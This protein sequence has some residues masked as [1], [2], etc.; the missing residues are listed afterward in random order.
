MHDER[1]K[2]VNKVRSSCLLKPVICLLWV[3]PF[4]AALPMRAQTYQANVG[5][6][7]GSI[8]FQ[9]SVVYS[10]QPSIPSYY[11]GGYP[12]PPQFYSVSDPVVFEPVIAYPQLFLRDGQWIPATYSNN[13]TV[14]ADASVIMGLYCGF[15]GYL[16]YDEPCSNVKG[17]LE[18]TLSGISTL[19]QGGV[20][21]SFASN[22]YVNAFSNVNVSMTET[23]DL[24]T[25]AYS[26]YSSGTIYDVCYITPNCSAYVCSINPLICS[27]TVQYT[28]SLQGTLSIVLESPSPPPPPTFS[29]TALD[30]YDCRINGYSC[31][32]TAIPS[33]GSLTDT[34]IGAPAATAISA[35]GQ[36]AAVIM[37]RS[38]SSDP[39]QLNLSASGFTAGI[40]GLTQYNADYLDN[41]SPGRGNQLP[42]NSPSLGSCNPE[43]SNPGCVF[44]ALLWA[45]DSMPSAG[46]ASGSVP[47]TIKA[48]QDNSA[49]QTTIFLQPPPL[50]LVH[51]MWSSAAKAWP[52]FQNWLGTNYPHQWI[53]AADY[54]T[55][56]GKAYS[57]FVTQ[58]EVMQ[59]MVN[60]LAAANNGG[61]V[62]R[63][64]DVV[65]HSMGGLVTEYLIENH[66]SVSPSWFPSD[67]VHQLITIGAPY[68]GSP[69]AATAWQNRAAKA[70][71]Q[72]MTAPLGPVCLAWLAAQGQPSL[73]CTLAQLFASI[74]RP[75]D[76]LQYMQPPGSQDLPFGE[77]INT[78][79]SSAIV[80]QKPGFSAL[81]TFFNTILTVFLPGQNVNGIVSSSSDVL[82]PDNSENFYSDKQQ[83]VTINGIVHAGLCG[84]PQFIQN[85]LGQAS[86]CSDTGETDSP[87]FWAQ[88]AYWLMGGNGQNPSIVGAN[89]SSDPPN[90]VLDLTGY[91]QVPAS[92]VTFSPASGSALTINS[93]TSI[94]ATSSAKTITEVLLFQLA[95][96]PTDT[97]LLYSTQSPFSIGFVPTRMGSTTFVA[98]ALFSDMTYATTTL[99]YTF[100]LSGSP[101]ALS[102]THAPVASLPLGSS[103]IVGAQALFGNGYFGNGYVDVSQAATYKVRSGT[104][105]VIR[106]EP[107]CELLPGQMKSLQLS[108]TPCSQTTGSITATG[109]GVDWLDVSYNGLTTSAQIMVG[110]CI[111]ALGPINQT[112]NVSGG[113]ARI[114]VTTTTGCSWIAA[115]G[116]ATWLTDAKASGTGS[117]AIE[118][119]VIP[120]TTGAARTAIITL[121]SQDVAITQT[122]IPE[123]CPQVEVEGQ[124]TTCRGVPVV[125][126]TPPV[127]VAPFR[128]EEGKP[129]S[130]GDATAK[131]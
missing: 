19:S 86:P 49:I 6:G 8:Q 50:V 26:A 83:P 125:P 90:P 60:A 76:T 11:P 110:S 131:R 121:A 54:G 103:I 9:A 84:E 130:G 29:I 71:L 31:T 57:D 88:A 56:S 63:Q 66:S 51:G 3:A 47:L 101:L 68:N 40:G 128:H 81:E 75:M 85:I 39:V 15:Q 97:L 115:D 104:D 12:G 45:P 102:L 124:P 99:N 108:S 22:N 79:M 61:V 16:E 67:P 1:G 20:V 41:P 114:Q 69:L 46:A 53:F 127:G 55:S 77:P 72:S 58:S 106:V 129:F 89:C 33:S 92:N 17:A 94:T 18:G 43:A 73:T 122:T 119:T 24:N 59:T 118:F 123:V 28:L 98:F 30:P 80:G 27:A 25:G 112:I 78:G 7:V 111:Y 95:S 44:L 34:V 13:G 10:S 38:N 120:N 116:G 96:D 74:G 2:P 91:T 4:L 87:C 82:V 21:R 14:L 65:A 5:S 113:T 70:P 35:D 42:I 126:I 117:G 37:I 23:I 62:A 107:G 100:L 48:T 105:R 93:A 36:S 64:L 32:S 109:S 52:D